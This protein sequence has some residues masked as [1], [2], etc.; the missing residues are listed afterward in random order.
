MPWEMTF[1]ERKKTSHDPRI[2]KQVADEAQWS[3][4]IVVE[5]WKKLRKHALPH[6]H[7]LLT[8]DEVGALLRDNGLASAYLC[9]KLCAMFDAKK[10]GFLHG[11]ILCKVLE[12]A[13]TTPEHQS[14][15]IRHCFNRF[16]RP[17]GVDH[18]SLDMIRH[19]E[20]ANPLDVV[21]KG[22]KPVKSPFPST[23]R[24]GA[25][26]EMLTGLQHIL[27]TFQPE[28]PHRLSFEEFKALFVHPENVVW[29]GAFLGP[30]LEALASFFAPPHGQLPHLSL[31]WLNTTKPVE[32]EDA[33]YDA[34]TLLLRELELSGGVDP[35]VKKKKE[36][37]ASSP[38]AKK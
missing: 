15:F 9:A 26:Y 24:A 13:L 28:V 27:E 21:K 1:E 37:K 22:G 11:L 35:F 25:N 6:K 10:E 34:D 29:V 16:D 8:Y 18:L 30:L 31:R 14:N 36:K 7:W 5:L 20:L 23:Q 3:N 38:T 12:L 19:C 17:A 4:T 32:S 2:M 33:M